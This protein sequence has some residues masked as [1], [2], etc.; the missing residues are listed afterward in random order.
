[1]EHGVLSEIGKN[2]FDRLRELAAESVRGS[3]IHP[4]EEAT[5]LI[6]EIVRSLDDWIAS[7]SL[8]FHRKYSVGNEVA[9]FIVVQDYGKISHLFVLPEFQGRGIGRSLVEAAVEV[10]RNKSPQRK[11]ELN[12]S[13]NA[14]GFYEAMGFRRVGPGIDRPGGCIP[15]EHSF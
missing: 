14:A 11:I 5:P 13:S 6:E 1:M 7:G 3:V 4:D 12:S 15:Y 9:G 10:C 8:G 2:D